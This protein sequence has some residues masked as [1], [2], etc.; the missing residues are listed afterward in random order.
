MQRW[1]GVSSGELGSGDWLQRENRFRS[2]ARSLQGKSYTYN[3]RRGVTSFCPALRKLVDEKSS[4]EKGAS[5]LQWKS[6][7]R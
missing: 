1:I 6:R 2:F 5:W 7:G 3:S 4:P